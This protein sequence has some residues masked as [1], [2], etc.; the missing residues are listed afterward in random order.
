MIARGVARFDDEVRAHKLLKTSHMSPQV[1]T[2]LLF[3]A[4]HLYPSDE[5]DV[6]D[7]CDVRGP[8]HATDPE[9]RSPPG[10]LLK[11]KEKGQR[12]CS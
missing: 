2:T 3:T 10:R 5:H 1:K 7:S 12:R 6:H 11:G 4:G 8:T 9:R